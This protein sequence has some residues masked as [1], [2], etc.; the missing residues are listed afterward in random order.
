MLAC[1]N[2]YIGA[3]TV[4]PD[5]KSPFK[6]GSVPCLLQAQVLSR[7]GT[8]AAHEV[9]LRASSEAS[10]SHS[11]LTLF[12]VYVAGGH[13]AHAPR[14]AVWARPLRNVPTSAIH[15]HT[16]AAAE[17]AVAPVLAAAAPGNTGAWHRS[18]RV[19]EPPAAF[20]KD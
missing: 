20:G 9:V 10:K 3:S 16:A 8:L 11:F 18:C 14:L 1:F 6:S 4:Q 7:T 2:S 19:Q 13:A 5:K 17:R 15:A 12:S